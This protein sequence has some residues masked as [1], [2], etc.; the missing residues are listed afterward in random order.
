MFDNG[1]F[2]CLREKSGT[3]GGIIFYED[4]GVLFYPDGSVRHR[5]ESDHWGYD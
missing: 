5:G 2:K 3:A 4:E 1:G